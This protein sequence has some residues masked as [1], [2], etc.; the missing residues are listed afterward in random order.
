QF[1]RVAV[2]QAVPYN[3]FGGLQ[4]N[5]AWKGPS[6]GWQAGGIQ[7]HEWTFRGQGGGSAPLPAPADPESGYSLSQNGSLRRWNLLT[8]EIK[9]IQPPE[10]AN[11]HLR[12]NFVTGIALD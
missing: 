1:Y 2:D 9:E 7:E 12:F 6:D 10:P 8:G 4:D 3:V 11:T 5:G